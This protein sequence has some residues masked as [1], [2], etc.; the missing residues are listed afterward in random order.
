MAKL[1]ILALEALGVYFSCTAP[2][3]THTDFPGHNFHHRESALMRDAHFPGEHLAFFTGI[4]VC[5]GVLEMGQR[6]K[7]T[8]LLTFMRKMLNC[9]LGNLLGSNGWRLGR[10]KLQAIFVELVK[11]VQFSGNAEHPCST[12]VL[13]GTSV[14]TSMTESCSGSK[15][16]SF[17]REVVDWDIK[18][19]TPRFC[20]I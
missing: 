13:R 2:M 16:Y 7:E 10:T 20:N 9:S 1:F 18:R 19:G 17:L 6:F 11:T 4:P 3:L 12:G 8:W 15:K 5:L 14:I